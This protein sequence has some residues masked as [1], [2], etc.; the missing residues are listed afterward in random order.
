MENV[1]R[2]REIFL[3]DLLHVWEVSQE[4]ALAKHVWPGRNPLRRSRTVT[5]SHWERLK[6]RGMVRAQASFRS[7]CGEIVSSELS[8]RMCRS[9]TARSR[10]E[11]SCFSTGSSLPCIRPSL[12]GPHL[13][14]WRWRRGRNAMMMSPSG[15]MMRPGKRQGMYV[16]TFK[17]TRSSQ[18]ARRRL[19]GSRCIDKKEK[20]LLQFLENG[21]GKEMLNGLEE[22]WMRLASITDSAHVVSRSSLVDV[23]NGRR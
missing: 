9:F 4:H 3:N 15:L 16:S 22:G 6:A 18:W 1:T 2:N 23:L 8:F 7:W 17:K 10:F 11:K 14:G 20:L 13:C 5:S 12:S 21:S 19:L